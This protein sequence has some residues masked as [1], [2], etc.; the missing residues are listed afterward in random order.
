MPFE[1]PVR[2]VSDLHFGHPGS[3]LANAEQLGTLFRGAGTAIFNGDTV[4]M[5]F[6]EDRSIAYQ[7]ME[8]VGEACLAVGARPIFVN[9]NH[10]PI[11]SALNHLDLAD[12]GFLVT[13]GDMLFHDISPWSKEARTIGPA[14]TQALMELGDDSFHDFEKRLNAGKRA[15][16]SVELHKSRLP[17]GGMAR[18]AT[19]L[20]ECWPP[21]RPAQILR[22]WVVT[23]SRAVALAR[24]FRPRARFIAIGHTHFGG[25]W[26][27]R[28]R[29]I[30][31]TGSFLP[32]SRRTAIELEGNTLSVYEIPKKRT[33]FELGARIAQFQV[34]KLQAHEGF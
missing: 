23:P 22:V 18:V 30:I 14:H 2:I 32:F 17:R 1:E 9:G 19:M 11:I 16:L 28:P 29:I 26:R 27:M 7:N 10:D 6:L 34:T 31:N 33:G 24:V 20:R 8:L 21:W 5:R 13:H 4:E 12:G 25:I 3:L 15:A